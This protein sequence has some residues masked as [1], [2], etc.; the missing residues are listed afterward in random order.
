MLLCRRAPSPRSAFNKGLNDDELIEQSQEACVPAQRS[1][2]TASDRDRFPGTG[3]SLSRG[4]AES[5]A[6]RL[7][8]L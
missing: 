6:S 7:Q 4:A 5:H 8:P 1:V 3:T 2:S